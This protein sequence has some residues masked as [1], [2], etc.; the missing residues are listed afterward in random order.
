MTAKGKQTCMLWR[1]S[2]FQGVKRQRLSSDGCEGMNLNHKLIKVME[3]NTLILNAQLDTQNM[4]SQ[5]EREQQ[6]GQS[7]QLVSA[8]SKI[9]DALT[10]IAD[11]L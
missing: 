2:T 1:R 11:K 3:K 6:K 7:D 5:L 8:L 10:R 9:S 4:N